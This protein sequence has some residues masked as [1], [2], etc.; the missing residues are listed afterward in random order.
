MQQRPKKKKL[1]ILLM[2]L[3]DNDEYTQADWCT[4]YANTSLKPS[5]SAS[6]F[7]VSFSCSLCDFYPTGPGCSEGG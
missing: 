6:S 5:G 1:L 4:D 3:L 2:M 7:G